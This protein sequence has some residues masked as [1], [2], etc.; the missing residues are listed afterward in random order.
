MN[1][2]NRI[3]L[4]SD[5]KKVKFEI[6]EEDHNDI[7]D[8]EKHSSCQL[9]KKSKTFHLPFQFQQ[10]QQQLWSTGNN[11]S[12]SSTCSCSSSQLNLLEEPSPLGLRLKKTPSLLDLIQMRLSHSHT[13]WN[14]A[15]SLASI[16]CENLDPIVSGTSADK[17]KASNFPASLL[18]I[19]TW[20]YVSKYEGDLVAK[21]YFAKHKLVWEVLEGGLKSKIEIQWS[22]IMSLN[23]KHSGDDKPGTLDIVLARQPL[24]FRETNPQPRKHT[25]WQATSD[26]TTGQA[27]IHRRHYLQC[28]HGILNKHFEKLIQCDPRLNL[29]SQ[30]PGIILNSP[31]FE[32]KGSVFED[33]DKSNCNASDQIK[34]DHVST[35]AVYPNAPSSSATLLSSSKVELQESVDRIP[36]C[37]S[38]EALSSSVMDTQKIQENDC[39]SAEESK[40]QEDRNQLKS[41]EL[42]VSMSMSDL[43]SHIEHCISEQMTSKNPSI[44][45]GGLQNED[46]L[47]EITQY[48]LSDS[49]L[50]S[51]SDEK[52]LMSRVNSLCCLL[53]KN[54]TSVQ[55]LQCY[56]D[57][58]E[59]YRDDQLE[60]SLK[61]TI[62]DSECKQEPVISRKDS[63]GDLL[64]H[65]PRIASL[66]QFL[67]NIAEDGNN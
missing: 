59:D 66:P 33:P 35:F 40:S 51:T 9:N 10:Q 60:S 17:L 8:E 67:F 41:R 13:H 24:F 22:D 2:T 11:S 7:D 25:L 47:E 12:S 15:F 45:G 49:Q 53:Q 48:L 21:C 5:T 4:E 50:S 37:F 44:F 18:K 64:L 32:L 31:Y 34:R 27:T 20:E 54:P 65:L 1:Y 26:F 58:M 38:G 61:K 29:L 16:Q 6:K 46:V 56:N 36:E 42:H 19:G 30:Q 63:V 28:P 14:P 55:N 39:T 3:P 23:A 62:N 52:S 57:W 43:V